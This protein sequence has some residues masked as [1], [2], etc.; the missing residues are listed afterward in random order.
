MQGKRTATLP[1]MVLAMTS[2]VM[3]A[4]TDSNILQNTGALDRLFKQAGVYH[5]SSTGQTPGF[6]ADPAW[7]AVAQ[8]LASRPDRW[9][10]CR[11]ARPYLGL[12][13]ASHHD[14]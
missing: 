12:Q 11:P 3:A 5:A 6:V 13:P 9:A 8:Q 7:P 4:D 10:L 14:E 2:L 1:I